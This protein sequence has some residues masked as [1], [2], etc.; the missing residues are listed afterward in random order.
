MTF[1]AV[2]LFGAP[3]GTVTGDDATDGCP[4]GRRVR[5]GMTVSTEKI[6]EEPK[7]EV[8]TNG[9]VVGPAPR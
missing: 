1:T 6:V 9:K 8:S 5:P 4:D 2:S 3:A 7:V